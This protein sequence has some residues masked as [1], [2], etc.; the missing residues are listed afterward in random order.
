MKNH[1]S[2]II[3]SLKKQKAQGD[4]TESKILLEATVECSFSEEP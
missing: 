1:C 2:G 4:S 3:T